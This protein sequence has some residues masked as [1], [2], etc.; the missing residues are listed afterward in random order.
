MALRVVRLGTPRADGEGLR[1]GTVRRPP[2]GVL[3]SEF[4]RQDW[5]DVWFPTLAPSAELVN[6]AQAAQ[7]A[8]QWNA[9]FRHY[10]AEMKTP[11]AAHAL[12]LLAA[13]SQHSDISVGCYCEDEAHC[14][15]K[16]LRELLMARGATLVE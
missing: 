2:R 5:Y 14:H 7:G 9:F 12:D 13:L 6:Q 1:I 15:R 8:A 11:A 10:K 4:A 3:R 16:A